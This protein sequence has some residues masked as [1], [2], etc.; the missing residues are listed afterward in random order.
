MS[1]TKRNILLVALSLIFI[2]V[3]AIFAFMY[4]DK[5]VSQGKSIDFG[6]KSINEYYELNDALTVP[7]N[8]DILDENGEKIEGANVVNAV[9]YAPDGSVNNANQEIT[10]DQVGIYTVRYYYELDG[11]RHYVDHNLTVG[12]LK[13]YVS[14]DSSSVQYI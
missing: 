11:A 5:G 3:S 6:S 13:Y 14:S 1:R 8:V 7:N 4:L 9:V 12:K 10:L 2:S